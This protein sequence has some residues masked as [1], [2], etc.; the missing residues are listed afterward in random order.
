MNHLRICN[1]QFF[2][3]KKSNQIIIYEKKNNGE[4]KITRIFSIPFMILDDDNWTEIEN[5]H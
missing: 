4:K 3:L 2:F 1:W 5:F